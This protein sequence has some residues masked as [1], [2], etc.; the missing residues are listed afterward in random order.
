MH[1]PEVTV[2][3]G[4]INLGD[5]PASPKRSDIRGPSM[6]ALCGVIPDSQTVRKRRCR[7]KVRQPFLGGCYLETCLIL[8]L[9]GHYH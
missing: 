3:P 1:L 6:A 8:G 2:L 9:D 5:T 4:V 7:W